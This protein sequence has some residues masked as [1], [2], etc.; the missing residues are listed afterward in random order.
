M[1]IEFQPLI[2]GHQI[3]QVKYYKWSQDKVLWYLMPEKSGNGKYFK[4]T[5]IHQDENNQ[6]NQLNNNNQHSKIANVCFS[7]FLTAEF[8]KFHLFCRP[9]RTFKKIIF[10]H[11]FTSKLLKY[12][13]GPTSFLSACPAGLNNFKNSADSK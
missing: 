4:E 7:H 12:F 5:T 1:K 3:V 13:V 6:M 10:S 2:A 8:L 11:Y 9:I